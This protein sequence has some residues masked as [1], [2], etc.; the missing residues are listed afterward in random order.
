VHSQCRPGCE[1]WVLVPRAS[2]TLLLHLPAGGRRSTLCV[3]GYVTCGL[4]Y[5]T[6]Y[7]TLSVPSPLP[8]AG[9]ISVSFFL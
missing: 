9:F 6:P 8:L 5:T 2:S 4:P 3:K 1:L 7:K